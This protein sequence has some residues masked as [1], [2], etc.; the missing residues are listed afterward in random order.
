M[1]SAEST[2]AVAIQSAALV[3][4]PEI[5][6]VQYDPSSQATFSLKYTCQKPAPKNAMVINAK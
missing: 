1:V 4:R 5:G 2:S 3:T 6:L